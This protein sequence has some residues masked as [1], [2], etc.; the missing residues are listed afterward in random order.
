MTVDVERDVVPEL[1]V[2]GPS[3]TTPAGLQA[4]ATLNARRLIFLVLNVVTWLLLLFWAGCDPVGRR[5]DAAHQ[6]AYCVRRSRYSVDGARFLERRNRPVAAPGPDAG[7]AR[8][9]AI[10]SKPQNGGCAYG[11]NGGFDDVAER[12]PGSRLAAS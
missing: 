6:R 4:I 7:F 10:S 3:L 2:E 8:R 5:L 11:Q 1:A 9:R 12:G